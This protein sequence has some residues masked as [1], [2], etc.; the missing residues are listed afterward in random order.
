MFWKDD[1]K[2]DFFDWKEDEGEGEAAAVEKDFC[3]VNCV[4]CDRLLL[5]LCLF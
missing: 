3:G 5:P 4:G 1:W 2:E